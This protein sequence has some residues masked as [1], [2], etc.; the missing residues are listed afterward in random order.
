MD[1]VWNWGYVFRK[2]NKMQ[3]RYDNWPTTDKVKVYIRHLND[4]THCSMAITKVKTI[5]KHGTAKTMLTTVKKLL[6]ASFIHWEVYKLKLSL[7][8]E[9]Q[10]KKINNLATHPSF[11]ILSLHEV[12]FD[13]YLHYVGQQ[14]GF[15]KTCVM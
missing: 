1:C 8:N 6:W 2:I 14:F 4:F 9:Q 5:W 13:C 10:C 15:P 11:Q 7:E 3:L 12:L